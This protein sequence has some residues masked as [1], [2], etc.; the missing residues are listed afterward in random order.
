MQFTT[1]GLKELQMPFTSLK[2]T[3]TVC[4]DRCF[5]NEDTNPFRK[6]QEKKLQL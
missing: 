2:K 3:K 6:L 1:S 4:K 5:I